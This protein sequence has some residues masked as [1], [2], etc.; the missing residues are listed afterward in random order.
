LEIVLE[1]GGGEGEIL[2]YGIAIATVVKE[3]FE[4]EV[5]GRWV[6]AEIDEGYLREAVFKD[7]HFSWE[8]NLHHGI[9]HYNLQRSRRFQQSPSIC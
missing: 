8:L 5:I 7:S 3:E 2:F 6:R 1:T 9:M 4:G